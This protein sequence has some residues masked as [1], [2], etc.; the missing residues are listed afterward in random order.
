MRV[1]LLITA[2]QALLL[3]AALVDPKQV[4]LLVPWPASPL[5]ARF[6][7]SLY[8]SLGVGVALAG[9]ARSFV[10]VRIIL[11]GIAIATVVLLIL[12]FVRMALHPA[13]L[14]KFPFFWVLFY[15]IDP[16]MVAVVFWRVG[17]GGRGH[18]TWRVVT[19]VWA[20]QAALFGAV[21]LALMIDPGAARGVWPWAITEPQ[22]QIYSAFFLTLSAASVLAALE[23]RWEGVRLILVMIVLLALLV[24]TV[25]IIHLPRFTRPA[26]TTV[27]FV[28]FGAEA[29]VFGGLLLRGTLRRT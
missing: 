12:T 15:V 26:E 23:E 19:W 2:A 25:S 28:V 3:V 29:V 11:V 7:A 18:P 22:A 10:E 5:N 1:V 4:S 6:I 20:V 21:G 24:L 16:L 8:V 17:W 9:T 27:W 13:E 14:Q